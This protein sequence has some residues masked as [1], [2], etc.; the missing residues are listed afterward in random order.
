[1]TASGASPALHHTAIAVHDLDRSIA[2]Y[3]DHFGGEVEVVLRDIGD[4]QIAELHR[5]PKALFTLAFVRFGATRL[6]FFQFADPEDGREIDARAH[7]FGIRHIGF[8]IDDVNGAYDRMTAAGVTF[9]RPPY[10]VPDGDAAGTVLAFCLDPDGNRVELIQP[11]D[12]SHSAAPA[13]TADA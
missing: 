13:S 9:T 11:A 12:T 6:E 7:D 5:L 1:M 10:V 2:F 8:E 3:A 4:P